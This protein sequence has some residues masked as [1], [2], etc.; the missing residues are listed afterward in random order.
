MIFSFFVLLGFFY[1]YYIYAIENTERKGCSK[2]CTIPIPNKPLKID[3]F[4]ILKTIKDDNINV[5]L[6]ENGFIFPKYK[7]EIIILEIFGKDCTY[8]KQ[9][10]EILN[11]IYKF[12][13]GKIQ[14]IG[15]HAQD[16]MSYRETNKLIKEFHIDYP[17]IEYNDSKEFLYFLS[18]NYGWT[19]ILPYILII[20]NGITEFSYSGKTS[21]FELERDILS[22][23]IPQHK[24][25]TVSKKLSLG[26]QDI[27]VVS[28]F[29]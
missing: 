23:L 4:F 13:D 8:C 15:I 19:G 3:S 6:K 27:M 29:I 9:E 26:G 24:H 7:D 20:K 28:I 22:L 5:E 18:K 17:I 1:Y 25:S 16:R 10:L 12:Y 21:Y 11:K 2:S 14:I